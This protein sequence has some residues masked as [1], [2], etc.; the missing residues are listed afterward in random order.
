MDMATLAH[1]SPYVQ[2][3]IIDD[4]QTGSSPAGTNVVIAGFTPHGPSNEPTNLS[5]L[6]DFV[7]TFG[8]P[9][10]PAE[11]YAYNA[12]KQTTSNS[13]ANV[14]FTRMPY[15]SGAGIGFSDNYNALVFPVIGV[16]A[17]SVD[18]CDYFRHVDEANCQ[19]NFPWL[20]SSFVPTA[21]NLGSQN[22]N[23]PLN[24]TDETPG[25]LYLQDT[26]VPYD[27]IWT[28]FKFVVDADSAAENLRVFQLRPSLSGT[29]TV[30]NVVTSINLS[31]IYAQD[32]EDQSN[33][34]NDGKRLLV[35][36]AASPYARPFAVT[37]GLLSGQTLSGIALSA[38][39]IF[40]TFS[41][42]AVLKHYTASPDVAVSYQ[43]TLTNL[44]QLSAGRTFSV[45]T[46]AK[47]AST[48]DLLIDF[49]V[50][51][52]EAGISC[53]TI[54]ALDLKVPEKDAYNFYPL[55]G[56]SQLAD[57]NFYV[58]GAPVAQTLNSSEYQLLINDQF[59]WKCGA[60]ENTTASLDI[61]NNN[62]AA[63][64]IIINDAQTAQLPDFSGYY[65]AVNDN[66]NVN[67][68]TNFDGLT[69]VS[70]YYNQVCPGISGEWIN[71]PAERLNF[72]VSGLFNG[73]AGS[74]S[75]IVEGSAGT[76]FG[77]PAYNDS[78]IVSLFKLTPSQLTDTINQ[79]Q[80]TLV[81]TYTGSLNSGR[82]VNSAYGGRPVSDYIEDAV[83][84]SSRIQ[85]KVNPYLSQNNCWND[86]TGTP[87]KTVRMFREA[88]AGVFD[89]FDPAQALAAYGDSLYGVGANTGVGCVDSI[90]AQCQAKDI[91]DLPGK[92][93]RALMALENPGD[94]PIDL[95][96]DGGL[97]TIWATRSAVQ[98]DHCITDPSVCYNYDDAYY[99]DTTS[100]SPFDGTSVAS[101]LVDN[102]MS[103]YNIFNN[104]ATTT[105]VQA[106]GTQHFHIQDPLRQI[107]VNGRDFKVSN[108]SKQLFIDPV[109]GQPSQQFS[110]FS[111]NI[112]SY[113]KNLTSGTSSPYSEANGN[114]IKVTDD[115]SGKNVW[116]GDSAHKAS[117]YARNDSAQFPW[118]APLGYINGN[119]LDVV[120]IAINPNQRE[121]DLLSRIS[122][123]PLIKT[124]Q[125][126]YAYWNTLTLQKVDSALREN[127]IV[128]GAVWLA[129]S[130][131]SRLRQY[132]GRPNNIV[133]R[134]RV[135]NDLDAVLSFM[136]T[137]NGIDAYEI[138]CDERNNTADSVRQGILN[139]DVYIRFTRT[140]KF[141][142]ANI[143]VNNTGVS[144]TT[145]L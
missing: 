142:N 4:S 134:T 58:L 61:E 100:L 68:A 103:I 139:V 11:R 106:G 17:V 123:N 32:D 69:G 67:P 86:S 23:C 124:D 120:D 128:R 40:G 25:F 39:D 107:F 65:I 108:R 64:I 117:L 125:G 5:D 75:E 28:G 129:K 6:A 70:G 136:K 127:Y 77:T 52:V 56:D 30:Y 18:P 1:E 62:V 45:A 36:I 14:T 133:T 9:T 16:S 29:S 21:L 57:A 95:T 12:V 71:V 98:A 50:V 79:L 85:M 53:A 43:T 73:T 31:A 93:Q 132:I 13:P 99:I 88:T 84:Q 3:N 27:S 54:S 112:W 119:V 104:F 51:P 111:R 113:L 42:N 66:L 74:I 22:L 135:K 37:S 143:I 126:G 48:L 8:I 26:P 72:N 102:W 38:G 130:M 82:K 49:S 10:T 141:I 46:S 78:I 121:R 92:L 34:T 89:N 122:I 20:Y 44:A 138:V 110:T 80:S 131:Q 35:N 137:N 116:V 94:Y 91:G 33:L 60:Q 83:N 15:G 2:V 118:T 109:T 76:N 90:F 101:A 59:N 105:R 7:D 63:G 96:V 140:T 24:S 144:V 19:V 145:G 115:Y 81:E 41:T 114:W 47:D 55:P 97:S 87:Q